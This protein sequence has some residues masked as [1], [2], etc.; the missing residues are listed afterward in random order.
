MEDF[1][2]LR[3]SMISVIIP[4]YNREKTI[5]RSLMSVLN[6]TYKDIEVIVVDDCSTD[7]TKEVVEQVNDSRVRYACLEKNSGACVARNFGVEIARGDIIAFQ[8]SDDEWFPEKLEMQMTKL[9]SDNADICVVPLISHNLISD[10][11]E[12]HPIG[13]YSDDVFCLEK[14]LNRSYVSTQCIL[15]YKYCFESI[16]FDPR[17]PRLQDWDLCI[18][19]IQKYKFCFCE[20]PLVHQYIQGDSITS[21]DKK[22][23]QAYRIIYEK[24]KIDFN[25]FPQEKTKMLENIAKWE[26]I[27]NENPSNTLREAFNCSHS[28]KVLIKYILAK[29]KLL[30]A[31]YNIF[32]KR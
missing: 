32:E 15:G 3:C 5:I 6:Q 9:K 20:M 28:L 17:L 27:C 26:Y 14:F 12:I 31:I 10:E 1:D 25:S 19:L 7:N 11:E 16:K 24:Y 8:D 2:R 29:L 23:L 18:R 22:A 4:T 21:N 30:G 13:G